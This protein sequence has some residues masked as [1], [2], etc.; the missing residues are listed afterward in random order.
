MP[1]EAFLAIAIAVGVNLGVW[2]LILW[3]L[4]TLKSRVVQSF[5]MEGE[6]LVA[7]PNLG[8]WIEQKGIVRNKNLAVIAASDR[9]ILIVPV[10]GRPTSLVPA[11]LVAWAIQTT[12]AKSF[13][14]QSRPDGGQTRI[15]W[16]GSPEL[17][18]TALAL[19]SRP[20]AR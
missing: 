14:V 15:E 4:Q 9:R 8:S 17:V 2:A 6:R 7:G 5:E 11:D 19:G 18:Q 12:G 1:N 20:I 13:L 3:R 10:V 16:R